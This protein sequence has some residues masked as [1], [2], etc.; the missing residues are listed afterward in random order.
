MTPADRRRKRLWLPLA[1]SS[2]ALFC[3]LITDYADP[4]VWALGVCFVFGMLA[5]WD[6]KDDPW[7]EPEPEFEPF[8]Y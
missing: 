4:A 3:I 1:L 5:L 8:T 6:G 7:A 2:A